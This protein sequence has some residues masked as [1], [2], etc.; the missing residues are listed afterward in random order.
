MRSVTPSRST[1]E[2]GIRREWALAYQRRK[3]ALSSD[4]VRKSLELA[5]E[6]IAVDPS[7]RL[8]RLDLGDAIVDVNE[9][10][11]MVAFRIEPDGTILF[12][13]FADLWNR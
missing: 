13:A 5:E 2:A 7:H 11:M 6:A 1:T 4:E 10:G 9:P 12:V 3:A 8:N